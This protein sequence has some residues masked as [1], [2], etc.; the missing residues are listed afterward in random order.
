MKE[1]TPEFRASFLRSALLSNPML[2]QMVGLCPAVAATTSVRNAVLLSAALCL[3]L[4]VTCVLASALMKRIPRAVRVALYLGIGLALICP[5]LYAI[6]TYTLINLS[7]NIKVYLPLLAVNAMT[8]LH[9]EKVAVKHS[10]RTAFT[11]AAAVGLGASLVFLLVGTV[12]EVLGSGSFAGIDLGLPVT[13][14][15]LSLPFG[16][17]ILLGFLAAA[18][19]AISPYLKQ[20]GDGAPAQEPS[21]VSAQEPQEADATDD[22][23]SDILEAEAASNERI[24]AL[25]EFAERLT[26]G[27]EDAQ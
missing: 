13:L 9:C 5:L 8:A 14:K 17:F 23:W 7:L 21:A 18:L 15:G 12:R 11:D 1:Q 4:I 16:C 19:Q 26:G 20:A 2:V 22:L 10:V 3:D 25:D 27:E 6:E 24:A